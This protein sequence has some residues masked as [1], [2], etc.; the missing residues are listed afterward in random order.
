MQ[1]DQIQMASIGV[2][3]MTRP[4]SRRGVFPGRA[5]I[6]AGLAVAVAG[7]A[8]SAGSFDGTYRGGQR[9]TLNNNSS[10]C[11]NI[12]E[13]NLVLTVTDNKFVR[14]WGVATI[15]V[16]IAP[17][18]T[19]SAMVVVSNRPLRQASMKGKIS[20]G[21]LE[22]DIGTDKCAAHLSLKK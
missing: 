12:R 13:E 19:F 11:A 4:C 16:E 2:W 21:N 10:D 5:L 8:V 6:V 14:H 9:V 17:D 1:T 3:R 22:A 20:G 7:P 15:P 18:G